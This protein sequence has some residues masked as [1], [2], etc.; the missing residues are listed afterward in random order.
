MTFKTSLCFQCLF[1]TCFCLTGCCFCCCAFCCC[2]CCCGKCKPKLDDMED[3]PD[4]A[5][6]EG[7]EE[8]DDGPVNNPMTRFE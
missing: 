8:D 6:F 4:V 2:N 3:I 1:W 5:E 7:A